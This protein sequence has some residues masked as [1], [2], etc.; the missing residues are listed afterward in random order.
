MF[1]GINPR[2]TITRFWAS[3]DL[4]KPRVF[5]WQHEPAHDYDFDVHLYAYL[6]IPKHLDKIQRSRLNP[7]I[8]E[9]EDVVPTDNQQKL[10]SRINLI[11]RRTPP[12]L[13]PT[14]PHT[15]APIGHG[16]HRRTSI[17]TIAVTRISK[18]FIP[19]TK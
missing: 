16:F 10:T 11:R 8:R 17:I 1:K 6:F 19:R 3:I 18:P 4:F 5:A 12:T 15:I 7:S 14:Y 13:Q 2:I 9:P